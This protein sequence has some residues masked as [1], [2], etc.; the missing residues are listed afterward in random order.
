MANVGNQRA[1]DHP[2]DEKKEASKPALS[3]VDI[4][5]ASINGRSAAAALAGS[6]EKTAA[7]VAAHT[8]GSLAPVN[9]RLVVALYYIQCNIF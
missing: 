5:S 1:E 8:A 6:A 3:I 4:A 7:H 2:E 9:S